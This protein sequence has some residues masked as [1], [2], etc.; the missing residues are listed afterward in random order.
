MFETYELK[1]INYKL[2]IYIRV[3]NGRLFRQDPNVSE[4]E[5][6]HQKLETTHKCNWFDFILYFCGRINLQCFRLNPC[7][8]SVAYCSREGTL[9]RFPLLS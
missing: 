4:L 2:G 1:K 9:Y 6:C 7:L 8:H 5:N 3:Q